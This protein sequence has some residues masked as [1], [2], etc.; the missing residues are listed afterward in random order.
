MEQEASINLITKLN[1][2][3]DKTLLFFDL[4][5]SELIKC[6]E[7]G[8][9]NVRHLLNHLADAETV[10]Y[11]RI[12]RGIA[13]PG[14][15]IWGF[16]QDAWADNLNYNQYP[17]ATNKKVYGAVREAIIY[18]A[19]EYYEAQGENKFVHNET[20]MRTLKEEFDK[21]ASRSLLT[22]NL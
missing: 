22:T 11:D 20:G 18:L 13:N 9:W 17:L 8:K 4:P 19:K 14:Q 21:V 7:D 10:L 12:R 3:K 15:V 5:E 16:D 6:Y 1:A 2:T